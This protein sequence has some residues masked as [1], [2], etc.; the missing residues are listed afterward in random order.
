MNNPLSMLRTSGSRI[1]V[2][3]RERPVY[4]ERDWTVLVV[5]SALVFLVLVGVG[6]A[7]FISVGSAAEGAPRER[8]APVETIDRALLR[9]TIDFFEKR[10]ATTARYLENPPR[11]PDP[12]R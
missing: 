4:P 2:S 6:V 9:E 12:S 10:A 8:G 3:Y 1:A 5:C 11:V 7:T